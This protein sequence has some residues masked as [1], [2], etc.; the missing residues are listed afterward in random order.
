MLESPA[1][2][3]LSLSAHRVLDRLDVEHRH[4][5]AKENGKLIV[6]YKQFCSYGIH[7]RAVAP[8][9]REVIAL[10][11]VVRTQKGVAGN[12]DE[13]QPS[14]Y[15]LTYQPA[16]GVPGYGSDEWRA[17][18]TSEE[19]ERLAAEARKTPE[20]LNGRRHKFRNP[21]VVSAV[22]RRWF[23]PV[24]PQVVSTCDT[25]ISP[26]VVS[27][28]TIDISAH[29]GRLHLGSAASEGGGG[30]AANAVRDSDERT[31]DDDPASISTV[32]LAWSKPL[33]RELFGDE[34]NEARAAAKRRPS[35][36]RHC[37]GRSE[38]S[39]ASVACRRTQH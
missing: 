8:A 4:H 24:V 9:I 14:Q 21:Q 31:D 15:R 32:K 38:K 27:T 19:A 7:D 20:R 12:A 23:P 39:D 34:A 22:P 17:I 10:G 16:E 25:A 11:F 26:Q 33:A 30:S 37:F 36:R 35:S 2:R 5:G 13:R 28:P 1:W 29:H 3:A 6:T 18:T